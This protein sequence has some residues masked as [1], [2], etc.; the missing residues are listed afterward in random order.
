MM[1]PALSVK[2]PWA[3]M[4][5]S[6][7]KTIET[8]TW[9]TPYRGPLVI[10][11]SALP[12]GYGVTRRALCV[13][14]LKHCREMT[15]AD[16]RA[17]CCPIYEKAKAWCFAAERRIGLKAIENVRGQKWLF[18]LVLPE[19]EFFT[20]DERDLAYRLLD[21]AKDKGMLEK[22]KGFKEWNRES[23]GG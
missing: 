16:E 5:A 18:P 12:K 9:L 2:Q 17:A 22:I 4:I 19:L 7:E 15:V 13:V 23:F 8:R 20:P 3:S 10:C 11:S 1:I 21:W 6:G 14:F